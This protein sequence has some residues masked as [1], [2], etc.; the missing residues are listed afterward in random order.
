MR[1][2]N[3][4]IFN[5]TIAGSTNGAAETLEHIYGFSV[6]AIWTVNTP[7][8]KSFASA[9]KA[10]LIVQDLTYTAD[11][12]G[13]AGNSITIAYTAGATAGAEVVTVV[14]SAISVQ[15]ETGVST[16][17]QVKTAVDAS[18]TA[19]ALVDVSVSGTGSNAQVT[20]AVTPLAGGTASSINL[21]TE[22]VT[23]TAH[24]GVTGLKG[25][26]TTTGTLPTGLATST[27][28]YII[29]V[30]AN[31]VKFASSLANA[32]AGTAI[33]LT[34]DGS[35][36]HTFT[37]TALAGGTLKVQVTNDDIEDPT[38][39]PTWSDEG[40]ATTIS[41][42]SS[43]MLNF[44]GKHYRAFRVQGNLTAG[45]YALVCRVMAKGT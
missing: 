23:I 21:S 38:V 10:S 44:D 28:Y 36:T 41:A 19:A 15:I 43:V 14:G 35:G 11:T 18:I 4:T 7:T 3:A 22:V 5:D 40:S 6:Q 8:A 16:A 17:T 26:L 12:A 37:A 20:A 34:G 9:A 25:Q 32:Q 27:D 42:T 31:S 39:T 30:D 29:K 33:N 2:Y 1:V 24:G 13:T 45:Q